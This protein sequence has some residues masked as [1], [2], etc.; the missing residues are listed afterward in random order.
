MMTPQSLLEIPQGQREAAATLGAGPFS[1]WW[2][3]D[4]SASRR[5]LQ[6]AAG[7]SAALSIGEF[8]ATSFLSRQESQTLP[9]VLAQLLGRPG[10]IVQAAGFAVSLL[11]ATFVA[12]VVARA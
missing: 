3:I 6:S 2:T 9:V 8:G 10:E 4:I 12:V 11:M 5:A 1:T 7:V